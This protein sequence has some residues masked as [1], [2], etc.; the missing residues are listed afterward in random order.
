VETLNDWIWE[1]DQNGI[2]TYVSPR[3]RDLL[4]FEPDEVLG[5]TPSISCCLRRP[6]VLSAF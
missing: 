6:N 5:K 4:G 2:Y 3:V 1:I